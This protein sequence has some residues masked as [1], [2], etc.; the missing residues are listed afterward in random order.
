[1]TVGT[2]AFTADVTVHDAT[3]VSTNTHQSVSFN[4][5]HLNGN[6]LLKMG[7]GTMSIDGVVDGEFVDVRQGTLAGNG[8]INDSLT[9]RS[10]TLSPGNSIDTM[11]VNGELENTAAGTVLIEIDGTTGAG[12]VGGHDQIQVTGTASLDGTLDIAPGTGY[13]DPTVRGDRNHFTLITATEGI[14]G[15]FGTV[16][17][18]GTTLSADFSDGDSFRD[19]QGGGLFRHVTYDGNN[20]SLTNLLA[21]EG[22]ADGDIDI[23]DF[24]FPAA[25][26]ADTGYDGNAIGDQVSEPTTLCLQAISGLLLLFGWRSGRIESLGR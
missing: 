25:N 21:L 10:G 4:N 7:Q 22:D 5:L 20:V 3:T 19:H 15:T 11:T 1:M 6:G 18:N 14:T 26:F 16:N 17:Y 13:S 24:N 23:T 9:N 8:T 12:V 2:H